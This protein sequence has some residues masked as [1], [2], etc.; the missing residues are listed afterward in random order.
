MH[1]SG[2]S[3]YSHLEVLGVHDITC[4]RNIKLV[5]DSDHYS[6]QWLLSD[7]EPCL[8]S[9]LRSRF[10]PRGLVASSDEEE[11]VRQRLIVGVL[12]PARLV[13]TASCW[14]CMT[15]LGEAVAGRGNPEK[16]E[17]NL[18]GPRLGSLHAKWPRLHAEGHEGGGGH[19]RS[20]RRRRAYLLAR[21]SHVAWARSTRS[22]SKGCDADKPAIPKAVHSSSQ[23][24]SPLNV[25]N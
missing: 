7:P 18:I 1:I 15:S 9:I 17:L 8:A 20:C 24:I 4:T 3:G 23:H 21:S 5:N 13:A 10:L 25:G 19:L 6:S 12:A 2:Q 22:R 16:Q 11:P 14:I